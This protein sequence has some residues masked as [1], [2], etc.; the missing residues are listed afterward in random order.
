M[1][2]FH[3]G[4]LYGVIPFR[5]EFMSHNVYLR[6]IVVTDFDSRFVL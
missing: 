3:V 1:K 4:G 2:L 5:V 6:N